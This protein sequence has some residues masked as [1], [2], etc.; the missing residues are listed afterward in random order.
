MK[1]QNKSLL[2]R[3]EETGQFENPLKS[4]CTT[5]PLDLQ[6]NNPV[7]FCPSQKTFQLNTHLIYGGQCYDK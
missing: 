1:T 2:L 3:A 6:I 4:K 5:K 7:I